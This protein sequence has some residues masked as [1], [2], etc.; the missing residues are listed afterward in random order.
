MND[1]KE[2]DQIPPLKPLVEHYQEIKAPLGFAERVAAHL[3]D[4]AEP[5][6]WFNAKWLYALS[7]ACTAVIAILIVYQARETEPELQ[8][9]QQYISTQNQYV[10]VEPPPI[11]NARPMR[12]ETGDAVNHKQAA[13]QLART[14]EDRR[15]EQFM[16]KEIP[17]SDFNNVAVLSDVSEWL[18]VEDAIAA[19]DFSDM[20]AFDDINGLFD[21]T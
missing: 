14:A 18:E 21:S 13:R 17:G 10:P 20:P 4:D 6:A 5:R 15:V 16:D 2:I 1:A 8:I 9:A 11:E 19:P 12:K 7:F 3:K